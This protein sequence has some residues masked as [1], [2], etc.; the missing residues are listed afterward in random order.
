MTTNGTISGQEI[1]KFPQI[2]TRFKV[3]IL[4]FL[5]ISLYFALFNDSNI[6]QENQSSAIISNPKINDI[7]F[8]D[9]RLLS[10]KLRPTE[11]YRLT[12]VVDITGNIVTLVYGG[13]FYQYQNAAVKSIQYGQLSY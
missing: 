5:L 13:Y 9:F 4:V 8:L 1:V 3:F 11:K 7:Y 6:S 12:K 2:T 10:K